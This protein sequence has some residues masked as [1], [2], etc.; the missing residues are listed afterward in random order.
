[1]GS[2][3]CCSKLVRKALSNAI[4]NMPTAL[5]ELFGP[6]FLCGVLLYLYLMAGLQSAQIH[7]HTHRRIQNFPHKKS[8]DSFALGSLTLGPSTRG[9]GLLRHLAG[10]QGLLGRQAQGP[11]QGPQLGWVWV[12]AAVPLR[13][14]TLS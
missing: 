6:R 7:T 14:S 1:M 3:V 9:V 5:H 12:R 4:S 13:F 10:L 8:S 11:D 2:F